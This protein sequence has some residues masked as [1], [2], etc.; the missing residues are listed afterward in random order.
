MKC[1]VFSFLLQL[2]GVEHFADIDAVQR[3]LARAPHITNLQVVRET[4]GL[5]EL[6]GVS[7]TNTEQLSAEVASVASD[8]FSIESQRNEQCTTIFVLRK[9]SL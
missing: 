9:I 6:H 1:F 2:L 3:A 8:R 4:R 7:G 5:V